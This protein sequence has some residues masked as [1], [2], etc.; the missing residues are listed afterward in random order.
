M[1]KMKIVKKKRGDEVKWKKRSGV[2]GSL[3][4]TMDLQSNGLNHIKNINH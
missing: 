4:I 1:K 2:D 3:L